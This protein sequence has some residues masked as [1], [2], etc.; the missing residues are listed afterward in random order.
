M[1]TMPVQS[2]LEMLYSTDGLLDVDF[3][4]ILDYTHSLVSDEIWDKFGM[5]RYNNYGLYGD[6]HQLP[7]SSN[8]DIIRNHDCMWNG[9]C[10]SKE[11]PAEEYN[12]NDG[13]QPLVVPNLAPGPQKAPVK[14]LQQQQTQQQQYQVLQPQQPVQ[15]GRSVLLKTVIK[16]PAPLVPSPESPPMSDD[17]ENKIMYVIIFRL[18]LLKLWASRQNH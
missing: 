5:S 18:L 16:Q 12:K 2:E 13:Y 6:L 4:D 3:R 10:A 14:Q 11:H 9:R 15:P 7:Q 17:E 1:N 8:N